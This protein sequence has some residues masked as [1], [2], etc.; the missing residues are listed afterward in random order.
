MMNR[1]KI[2]LLAVLLL[3]GCEATLNDVVAAKNQAVNAYCQKPESERL[4]Y[5]HLI[6]TYVIDGAQFDCEKWKAG[7]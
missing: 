4:A 3:P 5:R 6:N 2:T 1:L 7:R